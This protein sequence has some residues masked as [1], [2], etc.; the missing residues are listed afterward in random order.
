MSQ[1]TTQSKKAS[2]AT[3][4]STINKSVARRKEMAKL[5]DKWQTNIKWL[6]D[7]HPYI[8]HNKR[9]ISNGIWYKSLFDCVFTTVHLWNS[10]PHT[11]ILSPSCTHPYPHFFPFAIS[12]YGF[13]HVYVIY[14]M[15][16]GDKSLSN[17]LDIWSTPL[18]KSHKITIHQ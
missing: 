3:A 18:N 4:T 16:L 12:K 1:Q 10:L 11:H 14:C 15:R 9:S 5:A 17:C 8:H 2:V 6:C 7:Q 13:K